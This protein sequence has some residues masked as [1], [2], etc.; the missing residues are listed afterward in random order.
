MASDGHATQFVTLPVPLGIEGQALAHAPDGA[1]WIDGEGLLRR[2]TAATGVAA[3][4]EGPAFHVPLDLLDHRSSAS[5]VVDAHGHAYGTAFD[6]N[7][8]TFAPQV[9]RFDLGTKAL[10]P[11]AGRGTPRFAGSGV[12]DGLAQPTSPAFDAQG[13]LLFVDEGHRQ[14]K[15]LPA[16]EL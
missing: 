11:L 15:R 14:L 7:D 13:D 4:A 5:L 16:A 6:A 1:L 10:T 3:V 9:W 2:W 12:D 8:E